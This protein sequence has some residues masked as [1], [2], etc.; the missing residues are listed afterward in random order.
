MFAGVGPFAVPAAK[1][2]GC[3]VY[4]NDLNPKSYQYLQAN[5]KLNKVDKLIHCYNMD[6]RDFVKHLVHNQHIPFNHV[7]M[8]LPASA[9]EFLDVFRHL[10][11]ASSA[12]SVLP[13][14]HCYTFVKGA[15]DA[16]AQAKLNVEQVLY[17][18]ENIQEKNVEYIDVFDV[19]DVAPKKNMICVSFKLPES[20][21]YSID[22]GN[23]KRKNEGEQLEGMPLEKKQKK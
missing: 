9:V 6:G 11:P 17:E 19:R 20:I 23:S 12:S 2:V 16:I 4:A 15:E 18:G 10:F 1:H 7:I 3:Q 22:T 13:V 5:S 8:N 14:V 21:A